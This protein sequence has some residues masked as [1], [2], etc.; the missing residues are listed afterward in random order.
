MDKTII[1]V[2]SLNQ[3]F[4]VDGH[5]LTVEQVKAY[6]NADIPNVANMTGTVAQTA[7]IDGAVT[8]ITLVPPSGGKG[9]VWT[10]PAKQIVLKA[11]A[12]MLA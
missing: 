8:T 10:T 12:F 1:K 6:Y 7:G 2:P 11:P 9:V 4:T 3:E 5:T